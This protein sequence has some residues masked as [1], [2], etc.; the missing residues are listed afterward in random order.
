[1]EVIAMNERRS[2]GLIRPHY[3]KLLA[4]ARILD[5]AILIFSLWLVIWLLSYFSE[6]NYTW[7]DIYAACAFGG[8]LL[9][10]FFADYNEVYD[11]WRGSPIHK[12]LL[13]IVWSWFCAVLT[14]IVIGFFSK[15]I[16]E[17]SRL[18]IGVWLILASILLIVIRG[19]GHYCLS[20]IRCQGR[21]SSKVAIVG[22]NALGRRLAGAFHAMPW[23]GY[24]FM[25]YYDDRS[26]AKERRLDCSDSKI[27]GTLADLVEHARKGRIDEIFVTLPMRSEKRIH[28]LFDM[29]ADT[30]T[31]AY[32]VPDIFVFNLVHSRFAMIQGVPCI[33]VYSSPFHNQPV[34]SLIKRIED[35][36]LSMAILAMISIPMLM[37]AIG[38]KLTSP[39]PVI[40]KQ[41]RYGVGG[42][43]IEVW[44]FR[45][46]RVT[47]NGEV[48]RQATR[49]DP[50][51]TPFGAFLR[52]YSL[53]ELP[54]FINVLQGRMSI[55]GPRPHA[56]AHNEYYRTQV[57][58]YMLRHKIKPGITGLAQVNGCRG[59]TDTL[60]KM[61]RRIANDLDYIRHWGVWL[62]LKIIG[63]TMVRVFQDPN[64]Y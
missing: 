18:A 54:Q 51:V 5:G 3:T 11:T 28:R 44:K 6:I 21:N 43:L 46:M 23:L 19:L 42:E 26:F 61:E 38:V 41:K 25:G 48:I 55:V 53:D 56:I 57:L 30:T 64:A 15:S 14:L 45:T 36:V 27:C 1:M 16:L 20:Y 29:L 10:Q 58:G 8:V 9:Y 40:F 33:S 59:E 39:G 4:L 12:E 52:R 50:R 32:Y 47:E 62:D 60:D 34:D 22:A 35:I 63:L 2:S 31:S 37:I 17:I 49:D 13:R 24:R 7:N